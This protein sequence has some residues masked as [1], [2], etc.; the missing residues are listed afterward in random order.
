MFCCSSQ[1]KKQN[2]KAT[3]ELFESGNPQNGAGFQ[4][5]E[6]APE[7]DDRPKKHHSMGYQVQDEN[8]S[9]SICPSFVVGKTP[10]TVFVM[11]V[12]EKQ[13]K[14]K[15]ELQQQEEMKIDFQEDLSVIVNYPQIQAEVKNNENDKS[16]FEEI[17][18][19]PIQEED[20]E[21][22]REMSEEEAKNAA[23]YKW[24][25][26][27]HDY[28]A[29]NTETLI[30]QAVSNFKPLQSKEESRSTLAHKDGGKVCRNKKLIRTLRAIGRD[31]INQIGRQILSGNL[32]L[33]TVSF[34][35]K[36]MI[37][38]SA[39][40]KVL[41]SSCLFPLYINRATQEKDPIERLK[42]I[43][44]AT[45]GNFYVNCSFLKPLNPILGE[46]ISGFYQDGT[47]AYAE[48]I[49]HHPP[50]SY[51]LT[52]GPKNSYRFYGYYNYEAKAGFNSLSLKNK[53]K[54]YL[55]FPGGDLIEYNFA[56]EEYSGSFWGPM[57]VECK[58]KINFVDK[59]N[60]ITACVE[61]NGVTW[62]PTDYLQGEIKKKGKKVCKIYG[63]YMGYIEFAE[64]RYW[65]V[66]YI[67][68]YECKIFKPNPLLQSDASFRQDLRCLKR[69]QVLEAQ[70]QKDTL[71]MAQRQEA[72]LRKLKK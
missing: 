21:D 35:I 60:D 66:N 31:I 43:I 59:K 49:S 9:A 22:D 23:I 15:Q 20:D 14:M 12:L 57:K 63:S 2:P 24:A 19:E 47:I 11:R 13:Q 68:P 8:V 45:L 51:F 10:F 38:K 25:R 52:I 71:E 61:L 41:M 58:G 53:G 6:V 33:T 26:E 39:L 1:K 69:N 34:P 36:A 32:N 17:A 3:Q 44:C 70:E 55:S 30:L 4:H 42:L 48:Q 46:T 50:V 37:P 65:D 29:D 18:E 56:G 7:I 54:R 62:K 64:V 16:Q 72:K 28:N 67:R 27:V 5:Q 40:E